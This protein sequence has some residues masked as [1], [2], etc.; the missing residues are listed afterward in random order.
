[1]FR[2]LGHQ[3]DL[4]VRAGAAGSLMPSLQYVALISLVTQ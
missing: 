3:L 2:E 4:V 1:M